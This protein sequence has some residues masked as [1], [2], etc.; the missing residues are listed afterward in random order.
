MLVLDVTW[1]RDPGIMRLCNVR[2]VRSEGLPESRNAMEVEHAVVDVDAQDKAT[3]NEACL[4]PHHWSVAQLEIAET[5]A[6]GRNS[7]EVR[8]VIWKKRGSLERARWHAGL[9]ELFVWTGKVV[10]EDL[11]GREEAFCQDSVCDIN[12]VLELQSPRIIVGET[13][14]TSKERELLEC[15]AQSIFE[16]LDSRFGVVLVWKL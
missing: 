9:F 8:E 1:I 13:K 16:S 10:H 4:H 6:V 14:D 2:N 11:L 12:W 5:L 7:R 3:R 15:Q